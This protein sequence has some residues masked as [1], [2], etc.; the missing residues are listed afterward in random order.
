MDI[1]APNS[2]EAQGRAE[3]GSLNFS[4]LYGQGYAA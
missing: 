1:P 4:W 2:D 3:V